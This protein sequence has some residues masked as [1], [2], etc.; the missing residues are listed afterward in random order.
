MIRKNKKRID[1][2][3]FLSETT[4]R[5]LDEE[6]VAE[7]YRLAG[8]SAREEALPGEWL[9]ALVD[10]GV[11]P[12]STAGLNQGN[13]QPQHIEI[14]QTAGLLDAEAGAAAPGP[15]ADVPEQ[16]ARGDV[17][18]RHGYTWSG[19]KIGPEG[20][21]VRSREEIAARLKAY[22]ERGAK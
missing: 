20:V 17:D 12:R 8:A 9:A 6:E 7:D 18:W 4:Y 13:L 2:R 15:D 10:A 19:E 1:P 16:S 11:D 3:Y 21:P 5:D 14:L 22:R